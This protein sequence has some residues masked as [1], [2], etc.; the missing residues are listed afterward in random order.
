LSYFLVSSVSSE[1]FCLFFPSSERRD[2]APRCAVTDRREG[3]SESPQPR[4]QLHRVLLRLDNHKH[5]HG[6]IWCGGSITQGEQKDNGRRH[7]GEG[8]RHRDS[9]R[10]VYRTI[11]IERT[12]ST[13][14][15]RLSL[16]I[17]PSISSSDLLQ[18]LRSARPTGRRNPRCW[19]NRSSR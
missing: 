10:R 19:E 8:T 5:T 4:P 12:L 9:Q 16:S 15:S 17:S 18:G 7:T 3:L 2:L 6:R 1:C 13:P 11:E 14:V